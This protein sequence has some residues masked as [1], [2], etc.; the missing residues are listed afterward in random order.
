MSDPPGFRG[1]EQ[2]Y[3]TGELP[4]RAPATIGNDIT[5]QVMRQLSL[6]QRGYHLSPQ[7]S[8]TW[9]G[10][11]NPPSHGGDYD[12]V[13]LE[14]AT[15][16]S[17][18]IEDIINR[19]IS[20]RL[21]GQSQ[22]LPMTAQ[23]LE[24]TPPP[25]INA[26]D[27]ASYVSTVTANTWDGSVAYPGAVRIG[28]NGH[29]IPMD[30]ESVCDKIDESGRLPEAQIV[31]GL[32]ISLD[33]IIRM[34]D[35]RIQQAQQLTMPQYATAVAV[36]E[37]HE[38]SSQVNIEESTLQD[39]GAVIEEHEASSQF[40]IEESTLQDIGA[41][42]TLMTSNSPPSSQ[43]PVKNEYHHADKE[44]TRSRE[45]VHVEDLVPVAS[46]VTEPYDPVLTRDALASSVSEPYNRVSTHEAKY[47][48]KE[49][50]KMAHQT[51]VE[52][53]F[54][55]QK[56]STHEAK[57]KP[58]AKEQKA[59]ETNIDT[60]Y[61]NQK[62]AQDLGGLLNQPDSAI[63]DQQTKE[64]TKSDRLLSQPDSANYDQQTKEETKADLGEKKDCVQSD[65]NDNTS[66]RE[67]RCRLLSLALMVFV[68]VV[69]GSS[70]TA[71]MVIKNG[72]LGLYSNI[73]NL[74]DLLSLLSTNGID[75][76]DEDLRNI[77]SPQRQ[78]LNWLTS[79]VDALLFSSTLDDFEIVQRY[80]LGVFYVSTGGAQGWG[81]K[82]L[83]H[84]SVCTWEDV[85]CNKTNSL[86]T[87]LNICK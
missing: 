47:K 39:I 54:S 49:M 4:S 36:I 55:N 48:R 46:N 77:K 67:R 6:Q 21:S 53:K 25:S 66:S 17:M 81:K 27:D 62:E 44:K 85:G 8:L 56:E 32:G 11:H 34:V 84:S 33:D 13:I 73:T 59:H 58:K 29:P 5:R 65:E 7:P 24:A 74:D 72:D 31:E 16:P 75:V 3:P 51:N 10:V 83:S 2:H 80:I 20:Q 26:A 18:N 38:A 35:E 82:W 69:I 37:E 63:Y 68:I 28:P 1:N 43:E 60:K 86:V 52:A 78:T 22:A 87:M 45:M 50:Q 76:T 71:V 79:S 12:P 30:E 61:P 40:N 14:G 42:P 23:Q 9:Q 70:V 19:V 64:E 57:S 41:H 15:V